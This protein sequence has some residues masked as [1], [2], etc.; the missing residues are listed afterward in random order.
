MKRITRRQARAWLDPMRSCFRQMSSGEVDSIRGYAVTRLHDQDAYERIDWCI[1]GFR[2]LLDRLC[3]EIDT[4]PLSTIEKKLA[5][6]VLLESREIDAAMMIFKRC[7]DA[8]LRHSVAVIKDAVLTEQINIE[9]E[10]ISA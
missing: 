4:K 9:L 7:E 1:A 3:P 10:R 6:G 5:S 2:W 8:L